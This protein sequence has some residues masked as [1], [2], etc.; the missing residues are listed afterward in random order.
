M[1][2]PVP[3][4]YAITSSRN[5]FLHYQ[6]TSLLYHTYII[7]YIH[8]MPVSQ[9][10]TNE[11]VLQLSLLLTCY[12]GKKGYFLYFNSLYFKKCKKKKTVKEVEADLSTASV[13][14]R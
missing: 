9:L 6:K 8:T 4:D 12:L 5:V 2:I 11:L 14:T 13:L 7:F 1:Q 10:T 3:L